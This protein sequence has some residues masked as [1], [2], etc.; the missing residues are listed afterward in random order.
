MVKRSSLSSCQQEESKWRKT[1]Y[2]GQPLHK[3]FCMGQKQRPL[4][5][6]ISYNANGLG[7]HKPRDELEESV[8]FNTHDDV[9]MGKDAN[10]MSLLLPF[11]LSLSGSI[12]VLLAAYSCSE[13]HSNE[14][15]QLRVRSI[16]GGRLIKRLD[17]GC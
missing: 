10:A 4:T 17:L 2:N 3:R 13:D 9:H 16:H 14:G 5:D 15:L 6:M 12:V 8:V 1:S 11:F 7:S